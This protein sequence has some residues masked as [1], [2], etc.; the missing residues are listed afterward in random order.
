M[1]LSER[2]KSLRK[3]KIAL[4]RS[5]SADKRAL[6]DRQICR[7]ILQLPCMQQVPA[8]VSF[9]S[10]GS[11]PDLS[12]V[13]Q[14]CLDQGRPLCLPR[15]SDAARYE[16][17]V[18]ESLHFSVMKAG[19]PQPGPSAQ[20]APEALLRDSVWLV[21]GVAFDEHGGRLGRGKGVYDRLLASGAG[22]TIGV[23]YE[24][25]KTDSLPLE[26]HDRLLNL[27]VTED[28]VYGPFAGEKDRKG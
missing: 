21:P 19:I 10:D 25:Q 11:E 2:K 26:V 7:R 17:V 18:A 6:A 14:Q 20:V 13:M 9:V 16:I 23:F 24:C 3:E 12:P 4:R 1:T 15:F 5:I 22:F 28:A 8:L 27:I